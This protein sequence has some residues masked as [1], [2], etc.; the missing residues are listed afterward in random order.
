MYTTVAEYNTNVWQ[1]KDYNAAFRVIQL[2]SDET[3]YNIDLDT[4]SISTPSFLGVTKEQGAETIYFLVDRYF[5]E[6]DLASTACLVEYIN[7]SSDPNKRTGFYPV[8]FYDISTYSSQVLDGFY[9]VVELTS[10]TY[11]PNKFYVKHQAGHYVK[12]TENFDPTL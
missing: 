3:I 7:S 2:P 12:A 4:R 10:G 9:K 8:P 11:K 1:L 5:G 6:M